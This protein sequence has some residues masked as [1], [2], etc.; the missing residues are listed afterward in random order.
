M[1]ESLKLSLRR[2]RDKIDSSSGHSCLYNYF[3]NLVKELQ[4]WRLRNPSDADYD[5]L[6]YTIYKYNWE[7]SYCKFNSP[8]WFKYAARCFYCADFLIQF[9]S[10]NILQTY[11]EDKLS[12]TFEMLLDSDA[13]SLVEND[14]FNKYCKKAHKGISVKN[15]YIRAINRACRSA[16]FHHPLKYDEEYLA[17]C[18]CKFA[19]AKILEFLEKYEDYSHLKEWIPALATSRL[20]DIW[21]NFPARYF[22]DQ[23][24]Y[25]RIIASSIERYLDDSLKLHLKLWELWYNYNRDEILDI[26]SPQTLID[27]LE[28]MEDEQFEK[29]LNDLVYIPS[30]EKVIAILEHF[31]NDDEDWIVNLSKRLLQ[32]YQWNN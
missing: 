28:V 7:C 29:I 5:E 4:D 11:L 30:N 21:Y 10:N 22:N 20:A 12:E 3:D 1:N 32:N 18:G 6:I 16:S 26:V 2:I 19:Y 8:S 23:S 25:R 14:L 9:I 15:H 13:I 27:I 24:R 31:S 17:Y